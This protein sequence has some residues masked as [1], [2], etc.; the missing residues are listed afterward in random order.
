MNAPGW[1]LHELHGDL[2][3]F[4]SVTVGANWRVVFRFETGNAYGVGVC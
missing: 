3:G 4:H 1:R 2:Q